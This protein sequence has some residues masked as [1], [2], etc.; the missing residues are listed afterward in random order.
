METL[1]CRARGIL[2][3]LSHTQSSE[4]VYLFPDAA[5][6]TELWLSFLVKI[7]QKSI[8]KGQTQ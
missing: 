6:S 2:G 5:I 1:C 3:K 4:H 8:L 7:A